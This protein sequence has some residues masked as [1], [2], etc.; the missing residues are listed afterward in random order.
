MTPRSL[1]RGRDDA[2]GLDQGVRARL[3]SRD[4]EFQID[5]RAA[6]HRSQFE[7]P[8]G[9]FD[10]PPPVAHRHLSRAALAYLTVVR[11]QYGDY[12]ASYGFSI[13][14]VI[15]NVDPGW[16]GVLRNFARATSWSH[17][18]ASNHDGVAYGSPYEGG[19]GR[20]DL[21]V[22]EGGG[23]TGSALLLNVPHACGDTRVTATATAPLAF[24][25][26]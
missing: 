17:L 7:A 6:F 23:L 10:Q 26:P 9:A 3:T 12:P 1:P 20:V 13:D 2:G 8:V 11:D 5:R 4:A 25:E 16:D 24:G 19:F 15:Q 22:V 21:G 14:V 18:E